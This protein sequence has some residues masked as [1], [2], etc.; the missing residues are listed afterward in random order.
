M[1][2]GGVDAEGRSVARIVLAS[3]SVMASLVAALWLAVR[4]AVAASGAT[5]PAVVI[6]ERMLLATLASMRVS[7]NVWE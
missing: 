6:A 7:A 5:A 3:A 4:R 2:A 1:E